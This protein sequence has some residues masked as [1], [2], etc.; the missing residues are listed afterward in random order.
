MIY[1]CPAKINIGLHILRK[2][3]DGYH[4]LSS[5]MLPLPLYDILEVI[6]TG[7]PPGKFDFES[8]G[9]A[10]PGS[11]S[12]N[13]CFKAYRIFSGKVSQIPVKV[14]LYKQI[15]VGAGL[16]GGSS[17][18]AA[19]IMALNRLTG[20]T[21]NDQHLEEL[22]QEAGSDCPFF[23]QKRASMIGGKGEAL[24]PSPI[25]LKDLYIVLMNPGIQID[26]SRAYRQV[27]PDGKREELDLLLKKPIKEWK[28]TIVNDFE[29]N[30]IN[31]HPVIG[32]LKTGLYDSGALF[33]SMSGSGSSVYGIFR[34]KKRI[35]PG[36][37]PYIIWQGRI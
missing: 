2:R 4:D 16:G 27:S 13:I 33:A 5:L 12:D 3:D 24:M 29:T 9:I 8:T 10:V 30:I 36:L 34:K 31:E 6:K 19:M 32:K 26:T 7:G 21:L 22:A 11:T 20:S 18:A 14:F 28:H 25:D 15:P 17:D 35:G 1:L 37:R 23:I